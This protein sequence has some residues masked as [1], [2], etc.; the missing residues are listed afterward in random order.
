MPQTEHCTE[1][2]NPQQGLERENQPPEKKASTSAIEDQVTE[3][4]KENKKEGNEKEENIVQLPK[5]G[6]VK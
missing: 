1:T 2:E 3:E 5:K 6:S 4:R